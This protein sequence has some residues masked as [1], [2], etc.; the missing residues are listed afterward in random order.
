[1]RPVK[2]VT[3]EWAKMLSRGKNVDGDGAWE[4]VIR[5]AVSF[6][7][8]LRLATCGIGKVGCHVLSPNG[9]TIECI[10]VEET[11]TSGQRQAHNYFRNIL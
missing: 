4:V 8:W 5:A 6:H 7:C 2:E 11:K 10:E 3:S 1:M 9:K